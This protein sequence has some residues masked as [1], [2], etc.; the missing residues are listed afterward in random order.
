MRLI[1]IRSSTRDNLFSSGLSQ[2]RRGESTGQRTQ[3]PTGDL[4]A[5]Q[6]IVAIASFHLAVL[7]AGKLSLSITLDVLVT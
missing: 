3:L 2:D 4:K 5:W 6:H 1:Q 7:I